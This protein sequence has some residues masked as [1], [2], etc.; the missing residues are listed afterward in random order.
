M[1]MNRSYLLALIISNTI[2]LSSCGVGFAVVGVMAIVPTGIGFA[3]V[4]D[5]NRQKQLRMSE[6]DIKPSKLLSVKT[7]AL[8]KIPDPSLHGRDTALGEN[9][10]EYEEFSFSKTAQDIL[11]QQLEEYGFEVIEF[12]VIR[13]NKFHLISNYASLD[14][15][16]ADA[17]LDVVPIDIEYNLHGPHVSAVVRLVM[18]DTTEVIYASSVQ[19]GQGM[20]KSVS[21]IRIESQE[22]HSYE[23]NEALIKDKEVAIERLVQGV[24]AVSSRIAQEIGA[25]KIAG[26]IAATIAAKEIDT[27]TYDKNLWDQALAGTGGNQTKRKARYIELRANQLYSKEFGTVLSTNLNQLPTSITPDTL[28]NIS[29]TY[30]SAITYTQYGDRSSLRSHFGNRPNIVIDIQQKDDVITGVMS[31]DRS[32]KIEGLIE[33][34]KITFNYYMKVPGNSDKEG[35][36]TWMVGDG[37]STLNGTWRGR[38]PHNSY[39]GKWNLTKIDI[40]ISGNYISD[41]TSNQ[42]VFFGNTD[43]KLVFTLDQ[44]GDRI[45][46]INS[47]HNLKIGGARKGNIIEFFVEPHWMNS[48][49]DQNGVWEINPDGISITGSWKVI[50][51]GGVGQWNLRRVE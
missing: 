28:I 44:N 1:N 39:A 26:T 21:G 18:A 25:S 6:I 12:P 10:G 36:G 34:N 40:D 30:T 16:V 5:H 33:G 20:E 41:I 47:A 35:H 4:T 22:D 8:L 46:A 45:T 51:W 49:Q 11:I 50:N 23:S 42:K 17:Y 37:R 43:G 29:G 27:E 19:Y 15:E 2:L 31:G 9:P 14:I 24:E 3:I 7:I 48:F 38:A 32:G 13:E